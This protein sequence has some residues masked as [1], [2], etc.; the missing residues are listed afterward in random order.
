MNF[1]SVHYHTDD[2]DPISAVNNDAKHVALVVE[3]RLYI[4]MTPAKAK[5]VVQSLQRAIFRAEDLANAP[6]PPP[7]SRPDDDEIPF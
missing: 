4:H 7:T 6:K 2:K 3:D 1:T 5:E